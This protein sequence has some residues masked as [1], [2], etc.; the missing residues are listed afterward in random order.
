MKNSICFKLCTKLSFL[1][2]IKHDKCHVVTT[3]T[4]MNE[5]KEYK[6]LYNNAL[7]RCW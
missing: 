4:F 6:Y 1:I 2:S 5:T 7:A 3:L